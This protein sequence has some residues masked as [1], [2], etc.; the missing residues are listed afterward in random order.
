MKKDSRLFLLK[1]SILK[2]LDEIRN[3]LVAPHALQLTYKYHFN[4]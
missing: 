3:V 4:F 1:R 2:K